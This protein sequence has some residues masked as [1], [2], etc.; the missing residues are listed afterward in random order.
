[1]EPFSF[2]IATSDVADC[3]VLIESLTNGSELVCSQVSLELQ[4]IC[5]FL[6]FLPFHIGSH[7]MCKPYGV[8][9]VA[10]EFGTPRHGQYSAGRG[11]P[12]SK[13][14]LPP[15]VRTTVLENPGYRFSA[16]LDINFYALSPAAGVCKIA[17]PLPQ[18]SLSSK[19]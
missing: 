12:S 14:L 13:S 3:K 16:S 15:L 2:G 9:R 18:L 8:F 10:S 17:L 7:N 19:T 6:F 1:M 11:V 4:E 5:L